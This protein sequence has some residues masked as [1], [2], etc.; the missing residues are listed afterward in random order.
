MEKFCMY[1]KETEPIV[2]FKSGEHIF[3]AGIGG[4]QKLPPEYVSHNANNAFSAMEGQVMKRSL[5]ALPRQFVGPGKRGNI[6]NLGKATKSTISL[7]SSV[8]NPEE[9]E[10]GYISLGKPY[11]ISQIRMNINGS[12]QFISDKSFGDVDQQ[13]KDFIK[14][15]NNYKGRYTLH[16]DERFSQDEFLLGVHKDKWY[17]GLS[18]KEHELEITNFIKKLLQKNIFQDRTVEYKAVQ[19][20]VNQILE[21]N[22]NYFRFCAKIMFNYLAFVKGRDFVLQDCFDP[23][24]DWIV[25]GGENMFAT[26]TGE[27][28]IF[29]ENSF[30]DQAHKLSIVQKRNS[31]FGHISFYGNEFETVVKLSDKFE[32][33]FNLEGFICDWKNKKEYKIIEYLTSKFERE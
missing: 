11:S 20:S 12:G 25:N 13:S 29:F 19:L 9:F 3:P 1:L 6:N 27:K 15:L 17:V 18:N 31:L 23:I 30:P 4:I 32:G 7:M 10:F 26:L 16:E 21:F 14:N 8:T 28:T 33:S 5:L 2:I 22:D 24:R